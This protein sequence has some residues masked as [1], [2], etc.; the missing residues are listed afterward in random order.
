LLLTTEII[1]IFKALEEVLVV[2]YGERK[3]TAYT[4]SVS[5]IETGEISYVLCVIS[6]ITTSG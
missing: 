5:A 1:D 3:K 4:G 2:G 6:A